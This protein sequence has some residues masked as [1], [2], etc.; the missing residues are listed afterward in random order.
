M[1]SSTS[2]WKLYKGEKKISRSV[3]I[4][5]LWKDHKATQET[6]NS[7]EF[8]INTIVGCWIGEGSVKH[9]EFQF[10][11]NNCLLDKLLLRVVIIYSVAHIEF[12][13]INVI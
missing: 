5:W 7:R 13:S 11:Y 3:N 12:L 8:W 2:K 9:V 1:P 4:W 6:E 10:V